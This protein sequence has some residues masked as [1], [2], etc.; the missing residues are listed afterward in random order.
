MTFRRLYHVRVFALLLLLLLLLWPGYGTAQ[1]VKERTL[2]SVVQT[3]PAAVALK[4]IPL[5]LTDKNGMVLTMTLRP[6]DI[7]LLEDGAP[8]EI[9]ELAQRA[10]VPRWIMLGLDTSISQEEFFPMARDAARRLVEIALRPDK[11]QAAVY[12]FSETAVL[13]QKLTG[14]FQLVRDALEKLK[15]EIPKGYLGQIVIGRPPAAVSGK[16]VPGSTS[17]WGGMAAIN[18]QVFAPSGLNALCAIVLFTDGQD[19]SSQIKKNEAVNRLIRDGVAVYAIGIGDEKYFAGIDKDA[20]R[21]V[22]ERTGGLAFFPRKDEELL[23]A[24][25]GIGRALHGQ[26]FISYK[27]SRPKPSA[28]FHE[29]KVEIVNPALRR[30]GIRL[31]YPR[32]YFMP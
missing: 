22:A 2:S 9:V 5:T 8:Q 29:L 17:L 4:R 27:S 13:R 23:T 26:Y 24:L 18:E 10:D 11:D 21:S 32:K 14:E 6:Q 31:T 12:S 7:R 15:V 3:D 20:L 25:T 30:Q 1:E 28:T 19:T 16:P